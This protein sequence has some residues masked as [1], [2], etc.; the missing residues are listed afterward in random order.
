MLL[1]FTHESTCNESKEWYTPRTIFDALGMEFDIDPCSP[2]KDIVSWIPARKHF[3]LA[4]DGLA[5]DWTGNAFVNPPYGADTPKW[6]AKLRDYGNG[7]ALV[8][9]R[10]DTQWFHSY[11]AFADAICF[12]R[13]R[14][15]FIRAEEAAR[16]AQNRIRPKGSCGAGSML[17]AFGAHNARALERCNL[18]LVVKPVI[19]Y[20]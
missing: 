14:V 5:R 3:T 19:L 11:I 2:G 17:A 18:G 1:G 13:G 15:N 12:I 4:D 20:N 16:Y 10:T 9:N 6:M 8:F 7:I